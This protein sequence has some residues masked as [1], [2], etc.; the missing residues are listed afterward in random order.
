MVKSFLRHLE[1]KH[2]FK[3][4]DRILLAVSG[5]RDSMF[6]LHLF[7]KA[8][9]NFGVAHF[10]HSTRSGESDHDEKFVESF[11]RVNNIEFFS[12]KIDIDSIIKSGKEKNFH[13]VSRKYRYSWLES[14]RQ[15][16]HFDFIATAHNQDD[17]IE[18][19]IYKISKGSGIK[20]LKGIK[21]INGKIIRPILHISRKEIDEFIIVNGIEYVEDSS[22]LSD[23][24]DRNYIRHNIIP[25]FWKLNSNFDKRIN[26]T[27]QNIAATDELFEFLL[28]QFSKDLI[29]QD[30]EITIIE[31]ELL[32]RYVE[33]DE[34]LFALISKFGF[35]ITQCKNIIKSIKNTGKRFISEDFVLT[36]GRRKLEIFPNVASKQFIEI[37][38]SPGHYPINDKNITVSFFDINDITLSKRK[39]NTYFIDAE[40]VSFPFQVRNRKP[41]DLF[42]AF[43]LKGK[44]TTV[45][46]Y[47]ID[48]KI[49]RNEKDKLIIF[50]TINEIFLIGE[51]DISWKVRITDQTKKILKIT[52]T[53]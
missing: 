45:K 15:K 17:N 43:G 13:E 41:M 47:L 32:F 50:E 40:T 11:C 31:N 14:V 1:S 25:T 35:N 9:L 36:I 44:S 30:G 29:V 52:I 3:F 33:P 18:T 53:D 2:L 16:D 12:V 26:T 22:N 10:N 6:L 39:K 28:T 19:F 5:G 7:I 48:K 34:L 38:N 20:G 21:E 23:K 4:Q 46:K 8:K 49:S 27:I 37:I 24:Y 42:Y 51:I